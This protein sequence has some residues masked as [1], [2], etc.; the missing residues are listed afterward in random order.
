[1]PK[2]GRVLFSSPAGRSWLRAKEPVE[3]SLSVVHNDRAKSTAAIHESLKKGV[4]VNVPSEPFGRTAVANACRIGHMEMVGALFM[5]G[6]DVDEP[7]N[8]RRTPLMEVAGM[9]DHNWADGHEQVFSLLM[10][11]RPNLDAQDKDGLTALAYALCEGNSEFAEQLESAGADSALAQK[12]LDDVR[13][14]AAAAGIGYAIRYGLHENIDRW[15][16]DLECPDDARGPLLMACD[17]GDASIVSK[18]LA[19]GLD[20]SFR[21]P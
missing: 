11:A 2:N 17:E 5:A 4:D 16:A 3:L 12:L 18:I 15:L 9:E 1:M 6:A 10:H 20:A 21:T 14:R 19:Y 7:D 13:P 8:E